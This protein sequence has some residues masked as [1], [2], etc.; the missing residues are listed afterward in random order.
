[1]P[2]SQSDQS[3][4][5]QA[6]IRVYKY[7]DTIN[8]TIVLNHKLFILVKKYYKIYFHNYT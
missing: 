6:Y 3:D 4:R 7:N 8:I 2:K 5:Y 1:M